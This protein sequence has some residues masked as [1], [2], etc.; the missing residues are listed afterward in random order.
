MHLVVGSTGFLGKE[1][2]RQLFLAGKPVR[3]L[4]R[5]TSNPATVRSLEENHEIVVGDLKNPESLAAACEGVTTVI[6]TASSTF[7]RQEGDSIETVDLKGQMQLV[8]AARAAGV[9]HFIYISFR[10]RENPWL[11]YPLKEAKKSVE[12]H[13]IASG[14]PYTILQPSY[15]MEIWLGPAVGFDFTGASAMVY[16]DGTE[17][18]SWVSLLDVANLAV[19]SIDTPTALN[20]TVPIGGSEALSPL[21]VIKIFEEVGGQPFKISH[22]PQEALQAQKAAAADPIQETFSALMMQYAQG[23]VIN[24]ENTLTLFPIKLISVRDYAKQVLAE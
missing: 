3:A 6:T 18:I 4:T 24:M 10:C 15:F 16:G 7:S 23:D 20:R 11:E 5:A 1:I 8:D 12:D 22:V 19:Q 21:E 9:K 17:P 2:C 14:I 13:L